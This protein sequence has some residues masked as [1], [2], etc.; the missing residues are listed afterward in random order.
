MTK[1]DYIKIAGILEKHT[2]SEDVSEYDRAVRAI[3]KD[4][5]EMLEADSPRFDREKF[6]NY[7]N[8]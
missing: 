7:I 1:Q 2:G 5:A 3:T 4:F 8:K 6:I